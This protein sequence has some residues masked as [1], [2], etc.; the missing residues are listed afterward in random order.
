[1]RTPRN[2]YYGL[3]VQVA[4]YRGRR[5]DGPTQR[6]GE[7]DAGMNRSPFLTPVA[8][9]AENLLLAAVAVARSFW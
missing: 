3:V 9:P 8:L 7:K 6:N 1:M 2:V 5:V 4:R